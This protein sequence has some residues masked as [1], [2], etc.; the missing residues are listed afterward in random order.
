MAIGVA[1]SPSRP[2][3]AAR[4]APVVAAALAGVAVAADVVFDP[5]RRHVPLCPFHAATGWWCPLCG[6][7]RAADA[8]AHLQ[9]RTAL[10]DNLLF[11]LALPLVALWWV[12]WLRRARDGRPARRAGARGVA[13]ALVLAVGFTIVRN[14]PAAS[15][16]RPG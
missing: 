6:G 5:A 9:W 14:L 7:L 13:A 3:A 4:R 15:A 12:D 8:L 10:H 1:P 16:L 2:A 11:V